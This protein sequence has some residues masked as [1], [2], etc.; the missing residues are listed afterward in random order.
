MFCGIAGIIGVSQN[1]EDESQ[2]P[3][4]NLQNLFEHL[5]ANYRTGLTTRT[6]QSVKR[7]R[8]RRCIPLIL[9]PR[10][11]CGSVD[12]TPNSASCSPFCFYSYSHPLSLPVPLTPRTSQGKV[13]RT[14]ESGLP[15]SSFATVRTRKKDQEKKRT[16]K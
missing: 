9:Q 14:A 1:Q 11:S 15:L 16:D 2:S 4:G 10:G 5:S 7:A 13:E 3:L 6:S 8:Y 12:Y